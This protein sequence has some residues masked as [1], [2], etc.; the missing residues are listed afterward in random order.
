MALLLA[1]GLCVPAL[2]GCSLIKRVSVAGIAA[3]LADVGKATAK[4]T[5]L[6]L[7]QE[8]MPAY[9]MLLD[10]LIEA[11]PREKR[12]LLAGAEAYC[13]Y[14][15]AFGSPGDPEATAELYLKGKGYALRAMARSKD[16]RAVLSEP[17][18]V[19]ERYV[20]SL[21]ARDVPPVFW[22]ASCWAGWIGVAGGSVKAMADL[23]RVVLLM[24]RIIDLEETYHYGGAHLFLGIYQSSRP[25][26][27]GGNPEGSRKHF[28]RAIE[29]GRGDY[30]M[31]YVYYAE[32]YARNTFQRE[33]FVSL[34][35]KVLGSP[36]DRVPELAFINTL[37]KR[38]ARQ[39]LAH[40]EDYF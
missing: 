28:E 36:V 25:K 20:Q 19:F 6:N 14:A 18:P 13:S 37:A 31:A 2:L 24:E 7:V 16:F 40:V 5:D 3:V 34:L 33:L 1:A 4:Q 29:I 8:G 27:Y 38:K 15:G 32:Y 12:L 17:Y 9:L 26:A 30:L 22:F 11:Y 23:P 39:L 21:S 10:G 35:E